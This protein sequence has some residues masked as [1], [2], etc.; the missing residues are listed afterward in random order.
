MQGLHS[1]GVHR[2][3]TLQPTK[4]MASMACT[5][6]VGAAL[7]REHKHVHD[8]SWRARRNHWVAGLAVSVL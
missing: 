8:V 5:R 4:G 1:V 2:E 3:L 7:A 6:E